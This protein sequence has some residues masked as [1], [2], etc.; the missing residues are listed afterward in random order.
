MVYFKLGNL[1]LDGDAHR[2][3]MNSKGASGKLPCMCCLN[4]LK[5][6][7]L[8]P[9]PDFVHLDCADYTKFV[10]ASNEDV[11]TKADELE[12]KSLVLNKSEFEREQAARGITYNP[13]G[14]IFDK[15]LRPHVPPI[16]VTTN[17]SMHILNGMAEAEMS[18]LV[19]ALQAHFSWAEIR[20]WMEADWRFCSC[21]KFASGQLRSCWSQA[22]EKYYYSS[23]EFGRIAQVCMA[24]VAI[25]C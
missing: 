25:D 15:D 19:F 7:S 5:I 22:R 12:E 2:M 1:L 16:D 11:W 8:L 24:G 17:D 20:T 6:G 14:L 10:F 21:F 4:V 18:V 23:T 13:R 3:I 9:S